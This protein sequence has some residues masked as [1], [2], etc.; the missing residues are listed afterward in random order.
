MGVYGKDNYRHKGY[1]NGTETEKG[2]RKWLQLEASTRNYFELGRHFSLGLEWSVLASTRK[3]YNS[4]DRSL[5]EAPTFNPTPSSY[6]AFNTAFRANSFT[7]AGV[8]PVYRLNET[9]QLRANCQLFLPFR[10]IEADPT[11]KAVYGEWF[12][13]PEFFGELTAA[14]SFPFATV[15]AY[16]NYITSYGGHWNFGLS[17]GLFFVAP[18][19]LR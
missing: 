17:L 6:N 18:R 8:I 3:L 16:G 5:V 19:L 7:T 2:N 10:R 11:G 13:N 15:A 12:R 4:Y 1:D 9:V 14:A